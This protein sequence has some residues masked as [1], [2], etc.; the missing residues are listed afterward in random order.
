M[1]ENFN[2]KFAIHYL[3]QQKLIN[4]DEYERLLLTD[5]TRRDMVDLLK[6]WLPEAGEGYLEKLIYCLRKTSEECPVHSSIADEI[7]AGL[8][9]AASGKYFTHL[10]PFLP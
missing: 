7:E 5:K 4:D 6:L 10:L 8:E 9:K 1:A 3:R 2:V